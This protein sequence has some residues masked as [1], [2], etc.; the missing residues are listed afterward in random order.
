MHASAAPASQSTAEAPPALPS[1]ES[2]TFDSDFTAFMQA[3]VDENVR[4]GALRKLLRDPRFNVM[5]GLD[6]Y[7][8]DYS[9]PSPLEPAVARTLRH[10]RYLF[11][12]PK[13]RVTAE[14]VV[15]DVPEGEA[16]GHDADAAPDAAGAA[17]LPVPDTA[18]GVAMAAPHEHDAAGAVVAR[19]DGAQASNPEDPES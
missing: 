2:L 8:D 16:S 9:K 3:G 7:I 17:A 14:G 10:A 6:V 19:G 12:P 13:T 4:R 11:D 15:E 5:D 1:V 18:T